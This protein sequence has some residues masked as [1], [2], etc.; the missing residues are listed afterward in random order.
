MSE[1]NSHHDTTINF[2]RVNEKQTI[3][4]IKEF[5]NGTMHPD[6][7]AYSVELPSFNSRGGI[8]V[9]WFIQHNYQKR[10]KDLIKGISDR[11][12]ARIRGSDI[13]KKMTVALA[14]DF[15][16]SLIEGEEE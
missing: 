3:K 16:S 2:W 5:P 7:I 15:L 13:L 12:N 10:F 4:L 11:Y 6:C 1:I 9:V 8:K 14:D